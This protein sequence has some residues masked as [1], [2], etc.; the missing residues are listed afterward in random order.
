MNKENIN[1]K[2]KSRPTKKQDSIIGPKKLCEM[3]GKTWNEHFLKLNGGK[4]DV[5]YE[6]D[7]IKNKRTLNDPDYLLNLIEHYK[8]KAEKKSAIARIILNPGKWE[9]H[10]PSMEDICIKDG[11]KLVL[12]EEI[13]NM[14]DL[15]RAVEM[16]SKDATSKISILL[17]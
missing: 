12:Y 16:L 13:D 7:A 10:F 14:E 8:D 15:S 5:F 17:C 4:K 3:H 9:E 6:I 1:Q 2:N 11:S